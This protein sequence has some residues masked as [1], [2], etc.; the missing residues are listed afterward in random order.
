[1]KAVNIVSFSSNIFSI[2]LSLVVGVILFQ[3]PDLVS[4]L[5][6][7][8]L[9]SFL[10]V[11]GLG[12]IV[13][14]SYQKGKNSDA[15][16]NPCILGIILIACGVV[17]IVCSHVIEQIFRFIIGIYILFAGISLII[18]AFSITDK[19]N[20]QFISTIVIALILIGGGFYTILVANLALKGIGLVLII[21]AILQII[22]YIL[23]FGT[24]TNTVQVKEVTEEVSSKEEDKE[25]KVIETKKKTTKKQTKKKK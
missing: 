15:S 11:Y 22:N 17:C 3:R 1:M 20:Y 21:Y 10:I 23:L 19:K 24:S 2:I 4:I 13:Y 9:G 14:F 6:S 18:K 8:V 5:I 25:I 16:I 12:S 7:Y